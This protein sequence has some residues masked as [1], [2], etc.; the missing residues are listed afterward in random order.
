MTPLRVLAAALVAALVIVAVPV[1]GRNADDARSGADAR[2]YLVGQILVAAPRLGDPRFAESVVYMVQHDAEGALGLIVNRV[3]G[4]GAFADLLKGLGLE[5]EGIAGDIALHYGGPVEPGQGF[6]LHT[7]DYAE[8][9]TI[10]V[11][12]GLSLTTEV[13]VLKA[14]AEGKGPKR[15]L[16]LL[17]YSGWGPHQLENELARNDWL[18]APAEADL[19]FDDD[20][21][22]KWRRAM[23]NAGMK[24]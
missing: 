22:S 9:G 10:R 1:A 2:R 5:A 17:G 6:V 23:R 21:D 19:I 13:G 14:M 7:S 18:T 15:A 3:L 12:G 4:R 8:P 20:P 11:P 24:L 16:F